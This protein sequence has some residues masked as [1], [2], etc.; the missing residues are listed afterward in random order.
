KHEMM[1]NEVFLSLVP[2]DGQTP[3]K[4]PRGFRWVLGEYLDLPFNDFARNGPTIERRRLQPDA[5]LDDAAG[6][7]RYF[8]EYESGSATVRDAKKSTSTMA[9]LDRYGTFFR[10]P[11]GNVLAGER[12][13]FYTRAFK[14][15]WPAEVFFVTPSEARRDSITRVQKTDKRT[16]VASPSPPPSHVQPCQ[17]GAGACNPAAQ[18][19][20]TA[21]RRQH[22]LGQDRQ[23]SLPRA[24]RERRLAQ[25]A[26]RPARPE[27]GH[28]HKRIEAAVDKVLADN[29][30]SIAKYKAG[31][32]NIVGFLVG[33]VMKA[34]GG[35]ANPKVISELLTKKLS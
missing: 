32:T 29:L 3:A 12:E 30:A 15:G 16:S 13:T 14:D 34:T 19:A 9:K 6:R 11:A 4:V 8:I 23:A 27:A 31:K 10:A 2:Q 18:G 7:R 5:V 35:K 22:H 17:T 33:Q 24:A 25:G 26:R 28:G 21:H 1:L 20:R